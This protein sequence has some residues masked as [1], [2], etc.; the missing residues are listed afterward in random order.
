MNLPSYKYNMQTKI[1]KFKR[2]NRRRNA[3]LY[4][5][6]K[7][8]DI[9]YVICPVTQER[10]VLIRKD[11]I[12]RVL[13]MSVAEYDRLYPGARRSCLA[14]IE[15]I[16]KGIHQ[17]DPLT[18]KTKYE[19]SQAKARKTLSQVDDSGMS[20]YDKKGQKTR[21]THMTNIDEFGRNGYRRQADNRLSTILDNGLT[22]EQNAHIKQKETLLKNNK[23]GSGGASKL[24]KK[25]LSPILNLLDEYGVKYYF[26]ATEYGIKDTDT[27]NYY[28]WDLTIPTLKLAIEYQ[29]SSWHADPLLTE[30][31]WN[32]WHPPKGKTKSAAEVLLY[33]YN[34]A[35]SL[36]KHRGYITYFVWQRTQ[37][38]DIERLACLLKTLIMK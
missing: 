35:R 12:E 11:Y 21:A 38:F 20:G 37:E 15:N 18:G 13:E 26:D 6:D 19:T 5:D 29:S 10:C 34:K 24:S 22:V 27:G 25:V 8:Q 23:T 2:R 33:D 3:H 31:E 1:E 14:R 16:K 7:I 9:D 30:N 28:F 36:F 4:D 32:V 17:V